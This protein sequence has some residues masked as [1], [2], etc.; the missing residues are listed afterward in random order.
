[1][2][3]E[4]FA[5][6]LLVCVVLAVGVAPPL[7]LPLLPAHPHGVGTTHPS[8]GGQL[9]RPLSSPQPARLVW[10]D[11]EVLRPH[12]PHTPNLWPL[13]PYEGAAHAFHGTGGCGP[14]PPRSS[15]P[16][17]LKVRAAGAEAPSLGAS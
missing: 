8:V 1:M 10:P 5:Y 7:L 9:Q 4:V 16:R 3:R 2:R 15:H 11:E 12:A 13:F 6:H 17:G 14:P